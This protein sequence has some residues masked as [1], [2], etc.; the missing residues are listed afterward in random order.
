MN[1][2]LAFQHI[3]IWGVISNKL[4]CLALYVYETMNQE[5]HFLVFTCER[6]GGTLDC[7]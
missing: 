6:R 7:D 3:Y 1:K 5:V 2:S 4:H